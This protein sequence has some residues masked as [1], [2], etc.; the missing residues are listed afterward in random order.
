MF[1]DPLITRMKES[2]NPGLIMSGNKDEGALWG[3]VKATPMPPG[4]GTLI[5]RTF[6]GSIQTALYDAATPPTSS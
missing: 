4:R 5:T 2:A 3:D 1:G 6:K